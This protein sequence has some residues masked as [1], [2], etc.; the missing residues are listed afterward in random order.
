[1][2]AD[3]NRDIR[4]ALTAAD[5]ERSERQKIIRPFSY[6]DQV[7]GGLEV[8]H[9]NGLTVLPSSFVSRLDTVRQ[10]LPPGVEAPGR[11]QRRIARVIDQCFDL[12]ERILQAGRRMWHENAV[13]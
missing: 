6:L 2:I 10:L 12:Q 8:L 5:L 1:M 7:I 11:W 4:S 3:A 9:L 13:A